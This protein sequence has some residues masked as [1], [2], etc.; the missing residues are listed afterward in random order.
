M[1]KSFPTNRLQMTL[2][3]LRR[4]SERTLIVRFKFADGETYVSTR[5]VRRPGGAR[6]PS[7]ILLRRQRDPRR[8]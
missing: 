4:A 8:K 3:E 1:D 7:T 2:A 5:P 6:W